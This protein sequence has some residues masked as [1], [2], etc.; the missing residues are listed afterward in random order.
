MKKIKNFSPHKNKIYKIETPPQLNQTIWFA[1]ET[2]SQFNTCKYYFNTKIIV[3]IT[4][5]AICFYVPF[6]LSYLCS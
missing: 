1:S 3:L 2:E 5:G 6:S 4:V